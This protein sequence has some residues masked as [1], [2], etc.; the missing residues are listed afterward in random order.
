VGVVYGRDYS[1]SFWL[2]NVHCTGDE[3]FLHHCN[4]NDWG[5]EDC[6]YYEEIGLNCTMPVPTL[7][8]R[9]LS[10]SSISAKAEV[11]YYAQFGETAPIKGFRFEYQEIGDDTWHYEVPATSTNSYTYTINELDPYTTYKFKASLILTGAEQLRS[12]SGEMSARTWQARPG[13]VSGAWFQVLDSS[14]IRVY[15]TGLPEPN[16]VVTRYVIT[17]WA[18]DPTWDHHNGRQTQENENAKQI[19][20]T[21]LN[22]YTTYAINIYPVNGAGWGE[23][24]RLV[25]QT[26]EAPPNAPPQDVKL[27][28]HDHDSVTVSWEAPQPI[29]QRGV[30]TNYQL[31]YK[32]VGMTGGTI[33]PQVAGTRYSYN[34]NNLPPYTLFSARVRART[35]AGWGPFTPFYSVRTDEAAPGEAPQ[36]VTILAVSS[37]VLEVS[38][39]PPSDDQRNGIITTYT[40]QYGQDQ[41]SLATATVSADYTSYKIRNADPHTTYYAK[42]SAS[43]SVGMGPYSDFVM[44]KTFEA[45][46]EGPPRDVDITVV[47]STSLTVSWLIPEEEDHNGVISGYLVEIGETDTG[48]VIAD[49]AVAGTELEHTFNVLTPYQEYFARVAAR[50]SAGQGPF[51]DQEVARLP[52]DIP[53]AAPNILGVTADQTQPSVTV[54]WEPL[55]AMFHYDSGLTAYRVHYIAADPMASKYEGTMDT[56]TGTATSLTL[57]L[58]DEGTA[59]TISVAAVNSEG[60]GPYSRGRPVITSGQPPDDAPMNVRVWAVSSVKL[61]VEWDPPQPEDHQLT[62]TDYVV[63]YNEVGD[64]TT[65]TRSLGAQSDTDRHE[66]D[67]VNLKPYTYYIIIVHATND[68]GNS[69]GSIP[70]TVRTLSDVPDVA[71]RIT[72]VMA[73]ATI[74]RLTWSVVEDDDARGIV[75][76]YDVSYGINVQSLRTVYVAGHVYYHDFPGLD[77]YTTYVWRVAARNVNGTGPFSSTRS[78]Q[79]LES[80]EL[81]TTV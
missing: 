59:Y 46:P 56:T 28:V 79:T 49:V 29:N 16:G 64:N 80:S 42:V 68:A 32:W 2:D 55:D 8:V 75:T 24:T 81:T 22:A 26:R 15:W 61:H 31:T 13:P 38:W 23:N 71:P 58:L 37:S 9:A 12:F 67:I 36:A 57:N 34:V 30:I 21:G 48:L 10:S 17:Y 54:T 76:G 63:Q 52:A 6:A 20:L 72:N 18:K 73:S 65:I 7:T 41:T 19:I 44:D 40:I 47:S 78:I 25:A 53:G 70:H 5:S 39:Q 1:S 33:W 77:P 43:T 11:D 51:S 69:P 62:I 14:R 4:A 27:Q 66:Y 3:M 50:T 74:A 60:L 35:S 45:A